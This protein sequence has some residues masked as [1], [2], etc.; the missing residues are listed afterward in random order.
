VLDPFNLA[1]LTTEQELHVCIASHLAVL[2]HVRQISLGIFQLSILP[3]ELKRLS[4]DKWPA[5]YHAGLAFGTK[6][7]IRVPIFESSDELNDLNLF[8]LTF[9]VS[10]VLPFQQ[11]DSSVFQSEFQ[12]V[13]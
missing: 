4:P 13:N 11:M 12:E 8:I 5:W 9:F 1:N 6:P 3:R 7:H 2:F 10:Q